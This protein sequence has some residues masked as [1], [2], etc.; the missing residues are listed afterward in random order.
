MEMEEP[1]SL[2]GWLAK[3]YIALLSH[4]TLNLESS[5]NQS[6]GSRGSF[7]AAGDLL[8]W[9]SSDLDQ[10][11][12]KHIGNGKIHVGSYFHAVDKLD[13]DCS[14]SMC[15][16]KLGTCWILAISLPTCD[17]NKTTFNSKKD[18]IQCSILATL[19]GF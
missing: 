1:S 16:V 15:G 10:L 11:S 5:F 2:K 7:V 13:P 14:P 9:N 8:A 6:V 4:Q 3:I 19:I 18:I 17:E 12:D